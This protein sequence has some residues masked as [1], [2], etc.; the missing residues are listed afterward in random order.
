MKKIFNHI[1]IISLITFGFFILSV[2]LIPDEAA[3]TLTLPINESFETA[4]TSGNSSALP[5]NWLTTTYSSVQWSRCGTEPSTAEENAFKEITPN[6]SYMGK[7]NLF[8]TT[9]KGALVRLYT[10]DNFVF[11]SEG[12]CETSFYM[13]HYPDLYAG[14]DGANDRIQF[15]VSAD[16][17]TSW[18]DIGSPVYR[19]NG[20]AVGWSSY[21]FS[22]SAAAYGGANMRVGFLVYGDA[23]YNIYLDDIGIYSTTPANLTAT[24]GNGN[25]VLNWDSV[26]GATYY[27]VYKS[28]TAGSYSEVDAGVA[29]TGTSYT[30][31]G[32][33]NGTPYYFVVTA[34][35]NFS[36]ESAYSA[37]TTSTPISTIPAPPSGLTAT[38]GNGQ[39]TLSWGSVTGATSYR[40][41]QSTTSG[42]GYSEVDAGVV[43]TETSYT[44]TGLSN[45]VNYYFVVTATTAGGTSPYSDELTAMSSVPSA[46]ANLKAA[47]GDGQVTLSWDSVTGASSYKVYQSTTQG[48]A[49]TEVEPGMTKTGT[50]YTV[51][52]LT[53]NIPYYFAVKARRS[54]DSSNSNEVCCKPLK[55]EA[56]AGSGTSADPYIIDNPYDLVWMSANISTVNAVYFKQTVDIDMTGVDLTPIGNNAYSF[57]GIYDGSGRTISN[58]TINSNLTSIGLFGRIYDGTVKNLTLN[59]ISVKCTGTAISD[60]GG[61]AGFASGTIEGCNVIGGSYIEGSAQSSEGA[62]LGSFG[63]GSI[64]NCYSTATITGNS[65]N[66][67]IGGIVG[68]V[69]N[70]TSLDSSVQNCYFAGTL[71]GTAGAQGGIAG[72]TYGNFLLSD[73][74]FL[75]SVTTN[76][77]GSPASNSGASPATDASLKQQLANWNYSTVWYL[78]AGNKYPD[79]R[80]PAPC[81][82]DIV[83]TVNP[84]GTDDTLTVSGVAANDIIKVYNAPTG[85]DLIATRTVAAGPTSEAVSIGKINT[86]S[87]SVYVSVTSSFR[88][89]SGRIQKGI[90]SAPTGVTA[91]AGDRQA[92]VSFTA[93]A[94]DG[95]S[96]VT[97]YTVTSD[98]AGGIDSNAGSTGLSHVITG[99][100]NG[101]AYTF[102]VTATNSIGTGAA[103]A[104][105]AAVTPV[106]APGA[107]TG[108]TATAGDRQATVSFTAPASDGG[109]AVTGYTV[110]SDPAGGIDSNAGSTGLSHVIT[111]L[112][113]GTAYTFTVIATNS[114]GTGAASAPSAAVTPATVPGAPTG[115]TATAGDRQ[116]TVSFTAPASDGGSAVT[117]YTVTS[118]PAGG[119]DSNAGSTGL[120]HVITGLT[121]GTAY[122]FTV[123]ATNSIGTGAASAP[124]TAVIP[125][126]SSTI[127]PAAAT[128][129]K[130]TSAQADI[131]VILT[132]NGNI[133]SSIQNGAATL[134]KDTDYSIS[135]TTVTILKAYLAG[136]ATGTLTLTFNFSAGSA[137]TLI[138]TIIDS[139]GPVNHAPTAKSPVPTQTITGTGS[140][141]F[142]AGDVAEDT[143]GD[144]LT[145]TSIKNN[146][147]PAIATAALNS[148]TVTVT[149]VVYGATTV[150]VV[151]SD[152]ALTVD[153][154]VPI[155]VSATPEQNSTISPVTATFDK[156]S[157]AQ[158]DI[159]VALTLNGN[160]L[161][162]IQNG[163]TVLMKD[164]DYIITG[165]TVTLLKAYLASQAT[166]T[167]VLRFNFSA[168]NVQT[169]TI[170]V[171]DST[172]G[173]SG[174]TSG[175]SG[176]TGA[177]ST[178][179]SNNASIIVNGDT[180]TAGALETQ[181]RNGQTVTALTVDPAKLAGIL[182]A[183]GNNAIL[184]IPVTGSDVT[185][186]MLTGK[187][188]TDLQAQQIILEI[189]TDSATYTLPASEIDI[190]AISEQFGASVNLE[191][192]KVQIEIAEPPAE[193]TEL[194]ENAAAAG[195]FTIVAPAVNFAVS[196][197]YNNQ[198]VNISSF[199]SF[200]ERTIEIP[201]AVDPHKVTTGI[202]VNPDGTVRHIPTKI[203]QKDGRY[204]AVLNSLTN[205][206]YTLI[207]HRVEFTDVSVHWAKAAVN[208]MGS[209]MVVT[210]V[211]NNNYAPDRDIT[212]AEF[213]AIVV[214]ALGLE[215]GKGENKFNDVRA[216]DWYC[217]YITAANAYGIINGYSETAF[218]PRD[219]ITREQAMAIIANT[220]KVTGL[221]SSLTDS[222][223]KNLLANFTDASDISDYAPNSIALCLKTGIAS[224]RSSS[225]VAPLDYITRA[226]TAAMIQRLLQKSDLI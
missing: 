125:F 92:T 127:S 88:P 7:A 50:S 61:L 112:T 191:D 109:S 154:S 108:V 94:S 75:N 169:L 205:S 165:S 95:G 174:G 166:G 197:T 215:V 124:S 77:I 107:P 28:T 86:G 183:A 37:Y 187:M 209:R 60:V 54:E 66:S 167:A 43:K 22:L 136:Q 13:Y 41:Y 87:G 83:I 221:E 152:G 55:I 82:G 20:T 48:G 32:L 218:G 217:G 198:A 199:S 120:S 157:S 40:V 45:S 141:S 5:N 93:P 110:T 8:Y 11:P 139:T 51:S 46:P 145:V 23:G 35:T 16:G 106:G 179:A 114:I 121:N 47:A 186:S 74:Y 159:S 150:V 220:M 225:T 181:T 49:Y 24:A 15:Q 72:L 2:F 44:V 211:G 76:G 153:V 142:N 213:A 163:I 21:T 25:V 196:C 156:K 67:S 6:G 185:R 81:A 99:L 116:A 128:F 36:A 104:P 64:K 190:G 91:T 53:N 118:D 182:V 171:I 147:D 129:D 115:V 1:N 102:T 68:Y 219:K 189:K 33:T 100:T 69:T 148:G 19:V 212:R 137:R 62:I 65:S 73:N 29:K 56:P 14:T 89:E 162:G 59:N 173:G 206:T 130:K 177:A 101:T 158:A 12:F 63:S 144:T 133:L 143:D 111:G 140:S 30:V 97:G 180:M 34:T 208:D 85:G 119:I 126:S 170:T 151:V 98:P 113:N 80:T 90:P 26:K 71:A 224:G 146:P 176:T 122:A 195:E 201:D 214:K 39:I 184:T 70:G 57:K 79:L 132:L 155:A 172:S 135:G 38:E 17:G 178:T 164:A 84:E 3:A 96:A 42:S 207:W 9:D 105:S 10:A 194:V 138:I 210:G 226:E 168:G 192:I 223:V 117:G 123:T 27:K 200:V 222:E 131:P 160:T 4:N 203:V 204:H 78:D 161:S 216:S 18:N 188:I 103:S 193:T 175:S 134:V 149:G 58:L 52:G 202:I 31:T